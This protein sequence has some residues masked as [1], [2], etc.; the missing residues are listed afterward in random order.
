MITIFLVVILLF[1]KAFDSVSWAFIDD[2]LGQLNFP[3][4]WR[5]WINGC[6]RASRS[7]V[8]LNGCPTLEFQCARGVRQGDPLSPFLFLIVMEAFHAL[9]DKAI[10]LGIFHGLGIVRSEMVVSHLTYADDAIVIGDWSSMNIANLIRLLRGFFLVSGLRVNLNKCGLY[11]VNVDPEVVK[12]S[13]ADCGCLG[14]EL[15]FKYLGLLV[16]ESMNRIHSWKPVIDIF[17]SQLS[18]WKAKHLSMGGRL[19]LINS[20]LDSLPQYYF[21]LYKAPKMVINMLECIRFNFLWG[22]GD[23]GSTGTKKI[24]W[25]SRSE[26]CRPKISG[27]LGLDPL[28]NINLAL[29]VKWFWRFCKEPSALWRKVILNIHCPH[30]LPQWI[31]CQKGISGVWKNITSVEAVLTKKHVRLKDL[32]YWDG[33]NWVWRPDQE[34]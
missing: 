10:K 8:L 2:M 28:E 11:G 13:A 1:E 5:L 9:M 33:S 14:G 6:L 21:S 22:G 7:S 29:L 17:Q 24:H 23:G 30:S 34:G 3:P 31:P 26:I 25:I 16:G 15:P 19:V 18:K 27:G 12:S 32:I 20:V 4:K